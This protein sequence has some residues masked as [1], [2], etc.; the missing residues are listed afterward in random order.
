MSDQRLAQTEA[1]LRSDRGWPLWRLGGAVGLTG[2]IIV[3]NAY[4]PELYRG[5]AQFFLLI[6][7]VLALSAAL[8]I[9][10]IGMSAAVRSLGAGASSNRWP[11][12]L[13]RVLAFG[14]AAGMFHF[15]LQGFFGAGY[16]MH[17]FSSESAFVVRAA[18]VAP[19]A[20]LLVMFLLTMR[21]ASADAG[22]EDP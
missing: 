16:V 5:T 15:M 7:A 1:A 22:R 3:F 17:A 18:V 21:S 11:G 19:Y 4:G 8:E 10:A 2:L 14:A 13:L 6:P 9:L 12:F 20:M